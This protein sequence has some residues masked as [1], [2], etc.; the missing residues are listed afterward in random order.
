MNKEEIYDY[1]KSKN[2]WYEITEHDAVYNMK[3]L[4]NIELPYQQCDGKNLFVR[5][6]K[7]KNYYLIIIKGDKK[8]NLKDFKNNYKT[9]SLSFA[10]SEDLMDIMNLYPGSVTPLGL[11]NDKNNKVIFYLDSDFFEDE[12]IIG[13][14]PNDNT[15]TLWL[16]VEDL[17][18]IIKESNH[19]V[20]IFNL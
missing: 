16:K 18:S 6:D 3:E 9:R 19:Q 20:I 17:V 13:I 2:I 1:I 7:K 11:L 15:A 12:H 8:I 10:S 14:H 4:E 5:D